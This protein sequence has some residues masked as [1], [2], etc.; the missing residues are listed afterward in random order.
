MVS[1]CFF[2]TSDQQYTYPCWCEARDKCEHHWGD[3]YQPL[4][5]HAIS[6]VLSGT[7]TTQCWDSEW[8]PTPISSSRL[9]SKSIIHG[10]LGYPIFPGSGE[11]E[12]QLEQLPGLVKVIVSQQLVWPSIHHPNEYKLINM[13]PQNIQWFGGFTMFYLSLNHIHSY[14]DPVIAMGN[15]LPAAALLGVSPWSMH[16]KV[17]S[18]SSTSS[19]PS[20]SMTCKHNGWGAL[21]SS[22]IYHPH[23]CA[24][25]WTKYSNR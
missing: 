24:G 23:P 10:D 8:N 6:L 22:V 2:A 18:A 17:R 21:P 14:Y 1:L 13:M 15:P 16:W 7:L 4:K 9:Y 12:K 5:S 3:G 20:S 19:P 11:R 25:S